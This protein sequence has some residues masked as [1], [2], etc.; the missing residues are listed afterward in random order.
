MR[1][2][3]EGGPGL[4]FHSAGLTDPTLVVPAG[5][6]V[7]IAVINAD[8]ALP[9]N[10]LLTTAAPPYRRVPAGPVVAG[11]QVPVLGDA[12]SGAASA[13]FTASAAGS[14][15]HLCSVPGHAAGG[16]YGDWRIAA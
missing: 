6:A 12:S 8:P 1:L 5:A 11:A 15:H 4:A 10:W 7:T 13:T 2:T 3:L 14:F 16:M 9:H